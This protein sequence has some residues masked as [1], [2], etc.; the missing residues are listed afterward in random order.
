M[1]EDGVL[2]MGET[3]EALAAAVVGVA[4]TLGAAQL[5]QS[6]AD[7][8]KRLEL[9]TLA[10]QQREE[11]AHTEQV[12]QAQSAETQRRELITLRRACCISLNTASRQYQTAQI[13]LMHAL[14]TGTGVEDSLE[15]LEARRTA[16][17]DSYAEAQMILPLPVFN[18]AGT[19]SRQLN[20]G[21]GILKRMLTSPP[22]GQEELEAF[23]AETERTWTLLSDMRSSMRRDLGVDDTAP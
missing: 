12:R 10:E 8:T 7:R 13:T 15:Q 3:W 19:A 4:G 16:H 14:R 21:Y 22:A 11:R 18:A 5:T 2:D 20:R 1:A 23:E 17:R 6:R 9:Q